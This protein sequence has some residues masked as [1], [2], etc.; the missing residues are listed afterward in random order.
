M[1]SNV[2]TDPNWLED[3]VRDFD[4]EQANKPPYTGYSPFRKEPKSG[5]AVISK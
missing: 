1:K 5:T 2:P 4:K 3:A